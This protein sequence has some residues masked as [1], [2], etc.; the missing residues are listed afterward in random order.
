MCNKVGA[1]VTLLMALELFLAAE[2]SVCSITASGGVDFC[3]FIS[4]NRTECDTTTKNMF[5]RFNCAI[6][7]G[8]GCHTSIAKCHTDLVKDKFKSECA[9]QNGT[10]V[11]GFEY[12]KNGIC[13]PDVYLSYK[14]RLY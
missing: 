14:T 5:K 1:I 12:T 9:E 7:Y 3:E 6:E 2:A 4:K 11:H 13:V 8:N 10:V